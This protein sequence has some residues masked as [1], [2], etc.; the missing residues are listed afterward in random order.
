MSIR[1][2]SARQV[3]ANLVLVVGSVWHWLLRH[4]IGFQY[5]ALSVVFCCLPGRALFQYERGDQAYQQFAG[6]ER[7]LVF[8]LAGRI[9][10]PCVS[11]LMVPG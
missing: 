11:Y 10:F 1:A 2:F 9:Q 8:G 3:C 7:G 5:G 6:I 4:F